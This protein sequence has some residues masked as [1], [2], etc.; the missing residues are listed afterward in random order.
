VFRHRPQELFDPE[1][2]TGLDLDHPTIVM[3]HVFREPH[4][5]SV[6]DRLLYYDW[7]FVLANND[8][9]K[10]GRMC[11]V[12]GIE[13]QYPMLDDELVE[14][15]MRIP[16]AMKIRGQELR[17]FYKKAMAD[18]LPQEIIAKKKHGFGLP[19]GQWLKKSKPL[20]DL[21]YGSLRRLGQKGIFRQDFL[22]DIIRQHRDGHPSIHGYVIW[23]LV[24]LENWLAA[25]SAS[26]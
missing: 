23:D 14:F 8:L 12:A 20:Q 15:S 9:R 7:E 6:L 1:F 22:D 5:E 25:Q 18:F 11:E 21:I 19:F 4:A 26:F 17:H 24:M 2:L 13:V 3:S 16:A 10:V